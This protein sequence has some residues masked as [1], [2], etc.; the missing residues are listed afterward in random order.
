MGTVNREN[1][2]SISCGWNIINDGFNTDAVNTELDVHTKES[3]DLSYDCKSID[4]VQDCTLVDPVAEFPDEASSLQPK[5]SRS[6]HSYSNEA[7]KPLSSEGINLKYVNVDSDEEYQRIPDID[8]HRYMPDSGK[9]FEIKLIAEEMSVRYALELFT[10]ILSEYPAYKNSFSLFWRDGESKKVYM[11]EEDNIFSE[12]IRSISENEPQIV[13]TIFSIKY[14][15]VSRNHVRLIEN[16][17]NM[18]DSWIHLDAVSGEQQD[19]PAPIFFKVIKE[20]QEMCLNNTNTGNSEKSNINSVEQ[21]FYQKH[22]K[23][24]LEVFIDDIDIPKVLYDCLRIIISSLLLIGILA[25]IRKNISKFSNN[26]LMLINSRRK[27][28]KI[29]FSAFAKSHTKQIVRQF[30]R[31]IHKESYLKTKYLALESFAE[32]LTVGL[33]KFVLMGLIYLFILALGAAVFIRSRMQF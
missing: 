22:S 27:A 20:E 33:I 6:N 9:D 4:E 31:K 26:L 8:V 1:S 12:Q 32:A 30:N 7:N 19:K 11:L 28:E 16:I 18:L 15:T 25:Y 3:S 24:R 10:L 14:S 5:P 13:L 2:D 29:A 23:S 21:V 17:Q